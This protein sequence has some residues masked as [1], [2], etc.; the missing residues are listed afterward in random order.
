MTSYQARLKSATHSTS[1][2][3]PLTVAATCDGGSS[4]ASDFPSPVPPAQLTAS[5]ML[6]AF[7]T[8]L[9]LLHAVEIA[10][11]LRET[12]STAASTTHSS[13]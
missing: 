1:L 3:H 5:G 12:R 7:S 10:F 6:A 2:K 4:L 13:L 9:Q 11:N 8:A